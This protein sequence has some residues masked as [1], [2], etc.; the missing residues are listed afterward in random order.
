[1]T[2]ARAISPPQRLLSTQHNTNTE[3]IQ[4]DTHA[5]SGIRTGYFSI[6]AANTFYTL[7]HAASVNG[8]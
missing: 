1:M 4:T 3:Q 6:W 5:S 8:H 7:D 2:H